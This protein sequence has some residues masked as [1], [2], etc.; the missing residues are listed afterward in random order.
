MAGSAKKNT[1]KFD[2]RLGVLR[3]ELETLESDMKNVASDVGGIAD[4][5]VHLALRKAE[6]V[7]LSAY[8]LAEETATQVVHGVDEWACGNL[9]SAR[10]SIRDRPLSVLALSIGAGAL[11]GAMLVRR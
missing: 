10:K 1:N 7:A 8:R 9:D 3:S 5:R 11:V 6:D 2:K 4:D